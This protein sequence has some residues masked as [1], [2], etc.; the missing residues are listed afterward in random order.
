[1]IGNLKF[2]KHF[3][4]QRAKKKKEPIFFQPN[5]ALNM[6]RLKLSVLT[7]RDDF[8]LKDRRTSLRSLPLFFFL[9]SFYQYLDYATEA[10]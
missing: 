10:K 9:S 8:T 3:H 5:I 1:M 4:R 7:E 6:K 2:L